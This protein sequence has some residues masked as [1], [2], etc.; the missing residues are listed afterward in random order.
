MTRTAFIRVRFAAASAIAFA[1]WQFRGATT[2]RAQQAPSPPA[3]PEA[4]APTPPSLITLMAGPLT[5]NPDPLK[6]GIGSF[7]PIYG[8]GV[9]TGLGLTQTNAA[10]SDRPTQLDISN[11]VVIVQK[12]DGLLQF[13]A[14]AGIYTLPVVLG[15]PYIRADTATSD[16]FGPLPEAFLKLA[17]TDAFSLQGGKLWT[18]YGAEYIFTFENMNIEHGLLT[19]QEPA[20]SRGVQ[21][22]YTAGPLALSASFN[23]GFYSNRFNWLVGS[24][25]WTIDSRNTLTAIGGGALGHSTTATTATP[26]AQNNSDILN[27]IYT[28][29]N[30]PWTI[31]PYFQFTYVPKI[32]SLGFYAPAS[33][34]G[35]SVLVN[36]ALTPGLSLAGRAEIIASTGSIGNGTPNLLYGSGSYAFSLTL[37]PSWQLDRFF[38]RGEGSVVD[39]ENITPGLAFGKSGNRT[40][41][42]RFLIETGLLF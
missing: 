37:T 32:T 9:L 11:G 13:Y 17:P 20:I 19:L 30:T 36:Y 12:T 18:L 1:V 7:G 42:A 6:F 25:T 40:T 28:Y 14:Q 4:P 8:T 39:A 10:V 2:S 33:T 3:P 23:D 26:L 29:S 31:T 35:G 22:N 15:A 16:L 34:Y 41:Q 24:A 5:L 27:L 38:V 21:A